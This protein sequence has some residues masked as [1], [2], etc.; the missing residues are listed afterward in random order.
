MPSN[1]NLFT[2]QLEWNA[3]DGQAYGAQLGSL[4]YEGG[5]LNCS[6]L[7]FEM[8]FSGSNFSVD[9]R[10]KRISAALTESSLHSV[11]PP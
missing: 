10:F 5:E 4:N 2:Y 9:V 3:T 6:D 11:I 1:D 7:S 8:A